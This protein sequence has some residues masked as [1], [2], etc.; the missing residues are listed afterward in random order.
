[1]IIL[2]LCVVTLFEMPGQNRSKEAI[3]TPATYVRIVV[4]V[5]SAS[6]ALAMICIFEGIDLSPNDLLLAADGNREGQPRAE[7]PDK[8]M[9]NIRGLMIDLTEYNI[10]SRLEGRVL[11]LSSSASSEG[12]KKSN[13]GIVKIDTCNARKIDSKHLRID[14]SGQGWQ[15]ISRKKEQLGA[16]FA[17][18]DNIKFLVN[19]SMVGTFDM[20]Y[21][22]GRHIL[23]A[24]FVPTQ[25][26][27]ALLEVKGN[28]D[29][30]NETLWSGIIGAAG[31]LL[32]ASP[33]ERAKKTIRSQGSQKFT[34]NLSRGM[35]FILDM[36]SGQ[37]YFRLGTFPAGEIPEN[38]TPTGGKPFLVNSRGILHKNSLLMSGPYQT[39]QP[40][41]A[42]I[43]ILEGGGVR[44]AFVCEDEAKKIAEA[45]INDRPI[46]RFKALVEKNA[47]IGKPASLKLERGSGCKMVMVMRPLREQKVPVTYTY[48]MLY[49][50]AEPKPLVRCT[51]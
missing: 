41:A 8:I 1:M 45:Y 25:P 10:C 13:I 50:G 40:I 43:E 38:A 51:R 14:I 37:Q 31:T 44:A 20:N 3:M 2:M 22:Q 11:P 21:D 39:N 47:Q 32:G 48:T 17:V 34:S 18:D 46:P 36:C 4:L 27:D 15:W 7:P 9:G 30:D 6:F 5:I 26:V 35:T 29:V 23:T 33:E 16:T 12:G 28:V 24:W 49:R 19:I 42:R